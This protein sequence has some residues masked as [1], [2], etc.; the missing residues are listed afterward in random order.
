MKVMKNYMQPNRTFESTEAP[1]ITQG[2]TVHSAAVDIRHVSLA[3]EVNAP[4]AKVL[5]TKTA[6]N[7]SVHG[8][9]VLTDE[10]TKSQRTKYQPQS[11]ANTCHATARRTVVVTDG[12]SA[13]YQV[14][15]SS[16]SLSSLHF[17]IYATK[18]RCPLKWKG[19][20][21]QFGSARRR[22][23]R[24]TRSTLCGGWHLCHSK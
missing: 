24:R 23:A 22:R 2:T 11:A 13:G 18:Q 17:R 10:P 1:Q 9:R 3:N 20:C 14:E 7:G 4:S 12:V 15:A 16:V 8:D 21:K 5:S 6:P 19:P